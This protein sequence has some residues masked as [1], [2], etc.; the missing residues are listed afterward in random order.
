MSKV[1]SHQRLKGRYQDS[2]IL[3]RYKGLFWWKR[4]LSAFK[5]ISLLL[6]QNKQYII[7]KFCIC[8]LFTKYFWALG[9]W[10]ASIFESF[11]K[12]GKFS[13]ISAFGAEWVSAL[14]YKFRGITIGGGWVRHMVKHDTFCA[15]WTSYL[16]LHWSSHIRHKI[17]CDFMNS[18]CNCNLL[19]SPV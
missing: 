7:K 11:A 14:R 9:L 5:T 13:P 15:R 1:S 17:V 4:S 19:N 12:T 6:F 16:K 2:W 8:K 10:T 3:L 18:N